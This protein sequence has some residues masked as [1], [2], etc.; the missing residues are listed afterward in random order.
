LTLTRSHSCCQDKATLESDLSGQQVAHGEITGPAQGRLLDSPRTRSPY[1]GASGSAC[2]TRAEGTTPAG[3]RTLAP[4]GD[5]S[6]DNL[7]TTLRSKANRRFKL[8]NQARERLI[9]ALDSYPTADLQDLSYKLQTCGSQH[10]VYASLDSYHVFPSL[11]R[12]RACPV[13][14]HVRGL[15]LQAALQARIHSFQ[16]PKFLTLTL[17]HLSPSFADQLALL[18]KAFVRLRSHPNWQARV[19]SGVWVLEY[20]IDPDGFY[21]LHLHIVIDSD[22]FPQAELAL[23]WEWATYE[24]SCVVWIEKVTNRTAAY[25][26]KYMSKSATTF[27]DGRALKNH[28][29]AL[30]HHRFYGSWKSPRPVLDDQLLLDPLVRIG[31]LSDIIH[32]ARFGDSDAWHILECLAGEALPHDPSDGWD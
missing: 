7:E 30:K 13:C 6:L 23:L 12:Q 27:P 11:C 31:L 25:M 14:Q 24:T 29:D 28:L 3:S 4:A 2:S 9:T 18:R 5:P 1:S 26:A 20:T 22:Y 8:A 32:R 16:R 10:W 15:K 17:Q 21:H 19:A